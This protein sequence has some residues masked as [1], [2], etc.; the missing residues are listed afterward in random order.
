MPQDGGTPARRAARRGVPLDR[1]L[2]GRRQERARRGTRR[3]RGVAPARR[4]AAPAHGRGQPKR[5]HPPFGWTGCLAWGGREPGQRHRDPSRRVRRRALRHRRQA[6]LGAGARRVG[7]SRPAARPRALLEPPD[8]AA[9][10]G[11]EPDDHPDRAH[12][13]FERQ[14]AR[15]AARTARAQAPEEGARG[16]SPAPGEHAAAAAAA[17]SVAF[18]HRGM[19]LHGAGL[20]G[21]RRSVRRILRRQPHDLRLHRRC[22][23]PRHRGRT[24]HGPGDRTAASP[25]DGDDA[26]GEDPGSAQRSPVRRQRHEPFRDPVLRIPR[27]GQ[28]QARLLERGA[29]RADGVRRGRCGDAPAAEGHA[30]RRGERKALLQHGVPPPGRARRCS[31]IRTESRR[32]RTPPAHRSPSHAVSNGCERTRR[33]RCPP[34]SIPCTK[35]SRCTRARGPWRTTARCS[36]FA[37]RRPSADPSGHFGAVLAKLGRAFIAANHFVTAG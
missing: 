2:P 18:G 17:V 36:P 33:A 4:H 26:T 23:G 11:R 16:R 6:H 34:S 10:R 9:R 5:V 29:L 32:R 22:L 31:A 15:T 19:R 30:G 25:R 14:V 3:L 7:C 37:E 21:R 28:R 20:E 1:A 13:S 27:R 24:L 12:A 8:A 35:A